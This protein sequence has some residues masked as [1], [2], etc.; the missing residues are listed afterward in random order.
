[1]INDILFA[2]WFF[3]PAG[4]ANA[5]PIFAA[6]M[7][8]INNLDQP[9]DFGL[10]FRDKPVLGTHKT[11]RGVLS[12]TLL[13]TLTFI[14]QVS[15]YRHFGWAE[16]ISGGLNYANLSIWLGVLLSF[17]ALL[18]DMIKSFFKRQFNFMSGKSW[19]PFD[20]IDYILGGLLLSSIVI[21]L[22]LKQYLTII[23][24]WFLVHLLSSWIGYLVKLKKDPI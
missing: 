14:L 7:P 6:K 12:G 9:V 22:S 8:F 1:M 18:G 5:T 3:L 15:A 2:L 19:F 23:I 24:V 21:T 13:G 17:G 4:I 11:I 10:K 16:D 20:Q